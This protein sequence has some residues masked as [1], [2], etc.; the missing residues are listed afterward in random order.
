VELARK[1]DGRPDRLADPDGHD[2]AR[3]AHRHR[4]PLIKDFVPLADL[5]DIVFAA[6]DPFPDDAYVSARRPACSTPHR[7]LEP[8]GDFLRGD[9]AAAGRVRPRVRQAPRRE[10]VKTGSKREMVEH[11]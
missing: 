3:Q 5:D 11:P 7:H 6:W 8:I 9:R 1:R 10:N 2:P 4:S